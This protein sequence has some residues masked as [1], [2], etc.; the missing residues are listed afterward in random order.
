MGRTKF[1][2]LRGVVGW[3]IATALIWSL[4]MAAWHGFQTLP[5]YLGGAIILFPVGG[6]FWGVWVWRLSERQYLE[7]TKKDDLKRE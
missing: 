4:V 7:A 2:W 3:G 6:Y 5:I 1:I